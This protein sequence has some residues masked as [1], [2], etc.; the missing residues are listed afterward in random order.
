[1]FDDQPEIPADVVPQRGPTRAEI[2]ELDRLVGQHVT[3]T[4]PGGIV[5]DHD[6]FPN[7]LEPPKQ[8]GPAMVF[9]PTYALSELVAAGVRPDE[10]PNSFV[11]N[12][13]HDDDQS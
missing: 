5:P 2:L 3:M 1:M 7:G 10:I 13:I 8:Y 9:A 6:G 4:T 12:D 11:I